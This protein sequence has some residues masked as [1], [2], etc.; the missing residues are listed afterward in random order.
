M[1]EVVVELKWLVRHGLVVVHEIGFCCIDCGKNGQYRI[2][3]PKYW[4]A[5]KDLSTA[6]LCAGWHSHPV[7]RNVREVERVLQQISTDLHSEG[8]PTLTWVKGWG[9]VGVLSQ[10]LDNV[11]NLECLGCPRLDELTTGPTTAFSSSVKAQIYAN[12]LRSHDNE[13]CRNREA[14]H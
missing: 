7:I 6:S 11:F 13:H 8:I 10:Y 1:K 9:K 12:W 5:G 14:Q 2:D 3:V 4:I